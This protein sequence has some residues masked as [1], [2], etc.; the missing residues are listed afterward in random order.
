MNAL[1]LVNV[2]QYPTIMNWTHIGNVLYCVWDFSLF[3]RGRKT[4]MPHRAFFSHWKISKRVATG[5]KQSKYSAISEISP[6]VWNGTPSSRNNG[7]MWFR[8]HFLVFKESCNRIKIQ[9]PTRFVWRRKQYTTKMSLHKNAYFYRNTR[10]LKR[11][12][13]F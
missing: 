12:F 9:I 5:F 6:S 2:R 11:Y 4:R 1:P 13:P 3:S 8:L 7:L 10:I